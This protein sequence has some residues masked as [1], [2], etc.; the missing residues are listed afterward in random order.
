MIK[1]NV[2]RAPC[3]AIKPQ[4]LSAIKCKIHLRRGR[5]TRD[6]IRCALLPQDFERLGVIRFYLSTFR[7]RPNVSEILRVL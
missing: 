1:Q 6:A 5:D 2:R 4:Y 3:Q 7:Y